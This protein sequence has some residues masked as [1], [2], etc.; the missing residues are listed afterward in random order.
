MSSSILI[1]FDYFWL[2]T[3]GNSWVLR[4]ELPLSYTNPYAYKYQA[5]GTHFTNFLCQLKSSELL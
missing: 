4:T 1:L 5:Y 2:S 3:S